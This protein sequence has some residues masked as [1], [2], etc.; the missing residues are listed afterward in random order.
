MGPAVL[1]RNL[2]PTV[3]T[4]ANHATMRQPDN[5]HLEA[6]DPETALRIAAAESIEDIDEAEDWTLGDTGF[7]HRLH[8][9]GPPFLVS[10]AL[11]GLL[12]VAT[13]WGPLQS[14]SLPYPSS[15][16]AE[17]AEIVRTREFWSLVGDTLKGW[18][19][20]LLLAVVCAVPFGL[21]LGTIDWVAASFKF[22]ID[23]LRPIPSIA[24]LPL[25]VLLFGFTL[26]LKVYIVALGAFFPVL[27]QTMYG[28]RDVDPVA[29][30]TAR[31]YRLGRFMRFVFIDFMGA[32]PYIATG[33]R[34]AASV[35]LVVSVAVELLVAVPGIGARIFLAQNGGDVELMYALITATGVLGLTIAIVFARLERALMHW[36]P[37]QREVP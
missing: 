18:A 17:L 4:R 3:N 24:L 35:A 32:T 9:W 23:F 28:V 12:E 31:A 21:L 22:L 20:G 14:S 8:T 36:H 30:D 6:P 2:N 33:V 29:R 37:S 5:E 16:V 19:L 11:V 7:R 15:V 10:I 13:R 1:G 25:F 34:I 26:E 27:F